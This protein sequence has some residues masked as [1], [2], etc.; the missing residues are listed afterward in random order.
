MSNT[1]ANILDIKN[2][3]VR[4]LLFSRNGKD[5]AAYD[6]MKYIWC[7]DDRKL[8]IEKAFNNQILVEKECDSP[9]NISSTTRKMAL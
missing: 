6:E 3:E 1:S 8:S 7:S 4:Y 9:R 2:I 5:D